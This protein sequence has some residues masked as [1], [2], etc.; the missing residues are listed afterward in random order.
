MHTHYFAGKTSYNDD[1]WHN[2]KGETSRDPDVPNHTH[3]MSGHTSCD[4]GHTHEYCSVTGPAIYVDG[5]H[6]HMYCGVTKVADR[7]VH[8]YD[9][10]TSFYFPP[11][12]QEDK[13]C[14]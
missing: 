6:Y 5:K 8:S 3:R 11:L 9:A 14:K 4:D 2:Y 10:A 12:C 7:H 13:S 1:H